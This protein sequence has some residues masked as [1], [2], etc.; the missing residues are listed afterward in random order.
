MTPT[1][2]RAA[3]RLVEGPRTSSVLW[4][5]AVIALLRELL[6]AE[7]V[8]KPVGWLHDET[9]DFEPSHKPWMDDDEEWVPLYA[10]PQQRTPL[11]DEV[12]AKLINDEWATPDVPSAWKFARAIE[13][14]H[15]I[16]GEPT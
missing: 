15:G 13:R 9:G 3:E 4:G 12:V 14:A 16:T 6:A 10:A 2:R 1:Q 8:Q 7:Q 11:S 5:R